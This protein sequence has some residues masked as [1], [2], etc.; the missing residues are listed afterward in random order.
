MI[1]FI[2]I[3]FKSAF[4]NIKSNKQTFWLSVTTI[5]IS[6]F[7]L[8]LFFIMFLNCNSLLSR[9]N[10]QIQLIVYLDDK[11]SL[12]QTKALESTYKS[13][14]S[15]EKYSFISRDDAWKSFKNSFSKKSSFIGI[16]DFNPLPASYI[17][18][19][20][21][22]SNRITNIRKVANNLKRMAGVESLEYGEKWIS[23]F[24]N[25]MIFFKVFILC[26]GLVLC[27]GLILIISNTI[28]LSIYT[29]QN[30]IEL[31]A[32]LGATQRSIKA[33]LLMEGMIQGF[34]GVFISLGL[35]KLVH[36]YF[37]YSFEGVLGSLFRG[38]H[39][40]F[41]SDNIFFGLVFTSVFVGWIGS[42]I[43]INQF[44][45]GNKRNE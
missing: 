3:T 17:L 18:K 29:R 44:L 2:I 32:L 38:I 37:Q 6:F 19:F 21:D 27:F 8:G 43:S 36:L 16:I 24:E 40:Q 13:Y 5:A 39:F 20:Q 23:R 4:I 31:M 10:K 26:V 12:A 45:N 7:I 33:P 25:F 28:K 22:N 30:E 15:I 41:L 34:L 1:P 35:V 9:W 11:V 14:E 42:W